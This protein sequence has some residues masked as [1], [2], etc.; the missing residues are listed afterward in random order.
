MSRFDTWMWG[1]DEDE[2]DHLTEEELELYI[3]RKEQQKEEV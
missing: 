2:L 1:P 3:K